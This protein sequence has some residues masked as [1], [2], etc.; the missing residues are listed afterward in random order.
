MLEQD[1]A[2]YKS[3]A[4]DKENMQIENLE[5]KR[6]HTAKTFSKLRIKSPFL[7]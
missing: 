4:N 3:Y 5:T 7:S 6:L 2:T 1:S